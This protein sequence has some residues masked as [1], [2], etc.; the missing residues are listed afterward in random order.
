MVEIKCNCGARSWHLSTCASL[1]GGALAGDD[2][3]I[4]DGKTRLSDTPRIMAAAMW[5]I[6]RYRPRQEWGNQISEAWEH[7]GYLI[8]DLNEHAKKHQKEKPF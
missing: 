5:F 4:Q 7:S 8:E 2:K 6:M 1:R 3:Q